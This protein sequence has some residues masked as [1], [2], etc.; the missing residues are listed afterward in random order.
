[1]CVRK[2]LLSC[3]CSKG[4]AGLGEKGF[5]ELVKGLAKSSG[6]LKVLD[7]RHSE[8][9]T[10]CVRKLAESHLTSESLK[11][12][13]LEGNPLQTDGTKSLADLMMKHQWV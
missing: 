13:N 1:M 11:V 4:E 12:L 9:T 3:L 2:P 10:P 7:M 5:K 8:I 6:A